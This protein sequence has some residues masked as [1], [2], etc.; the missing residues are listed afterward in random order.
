L[1]WIK[2][3]PVAG[4]KHFVNPQRRIMMKTEQSLRKTPVEPFASFPETQLAGFPAGAV[5]RTGAYPK[6]VKRTP[7][8]ER[9]GVFADLTPSVYASLILS[10]ACFMTIFFVTFAASP[11]TLFILVLCTVYAVMFFGVPLT[12]NRLGAKQSWSDPGLVAFLRAKVDTIYGPVN[13]FDALVQVILVP[14]CLTIGGIGIA[15]AVASARA[16]Y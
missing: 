13:G 3:I 12:M 10:W 14:A 4:R 6:V 11:F 1:T 9:A 2:R 16:M 8:M 7:A 5:A 15:F